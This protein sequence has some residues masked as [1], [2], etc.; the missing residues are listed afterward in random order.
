MPL[1]TWSEHV[2]HV[3]LLSDDDELARTA[4]R[5]LE[6]RFRAQDVEVNAEAGALSVHS[7]PG[8]KVSAPEVA[9][10]MLD[11]GVRVHALH[12]REEWSVADL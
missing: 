7:E 8:R 9:Q 2:V 12:E 10:A 11:A 5:F 4:S 1:H 3:E 6:Q